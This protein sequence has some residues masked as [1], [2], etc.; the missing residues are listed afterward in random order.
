MAAVMPEVENCFPKALRSARADSGQSQ[1]STRSWATGWKSWSA[2]RSVS[3]NWR[4]MAAIKRS[5]GRVRARRS[6]VREKVRRTRLRFVRRRATAE[7]L[8]GLLVSVLGFVDNAGSAGCRPR[9]RKAQASKSR[10]GRPPE[11]PPS[12][13]APVPGRGPGMPTGDCYPEGIDSRPAIHDF[14]HGRPA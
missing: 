4:A 6:E 14:L 10:N 1:F 2:V 3:L 5:N 9:I 11:A 8:L 7:K 12:L 13:A